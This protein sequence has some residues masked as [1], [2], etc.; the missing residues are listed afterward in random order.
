MLQEDFGPDAK[1]NQASDC[2][3]TGLEKMTKAFSNIKARIRKNK[4]YQPDDCYGYDKIA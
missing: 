2:F 4:S 3:D 1:Q